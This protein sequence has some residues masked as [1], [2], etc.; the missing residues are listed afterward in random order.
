M[1]RTYDKNSEVNPNR[2][3]ESRNGVTTDPMEELNPE[4]KLV[5]YGTAPGSVGG[6]KPYAALRS[7]PCVTVC[8]TAPYYTG[9][10]KQQLSIKGDMEELNPVTKQA[11]YGSKPVSAVGPLTP[12]YTQVLSQ[13]LSK[14]KM[15]ESRSGKGELPTA[16]PTLHQDFKPRQPRNSILHDTRTSQM[17]Q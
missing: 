11:L 17:R 3:T 15:E 1:V 14:K 9:S 4:A 2:H 5:L 7:K 12:H 10:L 8:R 6:F 13:T 16:P